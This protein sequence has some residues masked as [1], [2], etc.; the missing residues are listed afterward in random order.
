MA[1]MSLEVGNINEPNGVYP[2]N[3]NG[4]ISDLLG[5]MGGP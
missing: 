1:L 4:P 2:G 5:N 3:I